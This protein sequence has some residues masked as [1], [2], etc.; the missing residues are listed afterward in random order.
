MYHLFI[1]LFF[2]STLSLRFLTTFIFSKFEPKHEIFYPQTW[3]NI[4]RKHI[5]GTGAAAGLGSFTAVPQLIIALTRE[6]PTI[7]LVSDGIEFKSKSL[8]KK[9]LFNRNKQ[10]RMV[11]MCICVCICLCVRVCAFF[12]PHH[13]LPYFFVLFIVVAAINLVGAVGSA[14]LLYKDFTSEAKSIEK[15]TERYV[16]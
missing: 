8:K 3:S 12:I 14:Y 1:D 13:F 2:L 5:T 7:P 9:N 10:V 15:F 11:C 6:N 4:T 16:R